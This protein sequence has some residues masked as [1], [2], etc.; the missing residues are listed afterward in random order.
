MSG[1]PLEDRL[2]AEV[3]GLRAFARSLTHD[4]AAA[5]DLVQETILRAWARLDSFEE[6]TNLR[7]WLFTILRNTFISGKRKVK[8]EVEDAEGH[9]A[10]R[11]V[12]TPRQDGAA[13]LGNFRHALSQLPQDQREA[14]MLVGAVGFTYDEA[15]EVCGCSS[16]TIK[17]R[18]NRARR[19]LDGMLEF[20]EGDA[21]GAAG[22]VSE[23]EAPPAQPP[24][25]AS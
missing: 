20:G 10:A 5:D 14:L 24:R 16:G 23:E 19:R 4:A 21:D 8:R 11:L 12:E 18:V 15:A 22:D 2:V 3:P 1:E 7:A 6:G 9:H 13:N 17:S 25:Q